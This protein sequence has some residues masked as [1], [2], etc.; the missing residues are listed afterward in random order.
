MTKKKA[1]RPPH[2]PTDESRKLVRTLSGFGIKQADI[3]NK[4]GINEET[5]R[6][7]YRQELDDGTLEA[8]AKV[9]QS[10]FNKAIGNDKSSVTAAIFWLKTRARWTERHEIEHSGNI[11]SMDLTKLTD[12]ELAILKKVVPSE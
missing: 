9:A 12:E 10:L 6:L 1:G 4:I 5:L 8:N 11:G 2:E 7:H 3:S